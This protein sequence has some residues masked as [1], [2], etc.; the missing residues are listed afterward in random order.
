MM[1]SLSNE[2]RFP[3][4]CDDNLADHIW[5]DGTDIIVVAWSVE[6][7]AVTRSRHQSVGGGAIVQNNAV[8]RAVVV[9]PGNR[10]TGTQFK[11]RWDEGK[12]VDDHPAAGRLLPSCGALHHN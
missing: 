3:V 7:I 12:S 9:Y 6:S 1:Q 4:L 8:R 2:R 5:M 11:Y 10:F